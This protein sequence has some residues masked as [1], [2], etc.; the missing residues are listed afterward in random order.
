MTE[1]QQLIRGWKARIKYHE[2]LFRAMKREHKKEQLRY[3]KK[4]RVERR[5]LAKLIKKG[6]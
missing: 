6:K 4:L 3:A 1:N 2:K 5:I